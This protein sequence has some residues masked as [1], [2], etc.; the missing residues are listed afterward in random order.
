MICFC[1]SRTQGDQ[2]PAISYYL[3]LPNE[4]D[5]YLG[6][7]LEPSPLTKPINKS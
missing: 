3:E 4:T 7:E 1:G 2:N 6:T 5:F